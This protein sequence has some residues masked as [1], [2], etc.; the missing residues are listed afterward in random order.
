[1]KP[2]LTRFLQGAL[3]LVGLAALAFL[4]WE[5]HVEG[6]NSHATLSEIYFRDPFLA[7]V[8][9]GST[10]FFVAL[11]RAFGLLG[12]LRQNGTVSQGTVDALRV[13]ARC[14]IALIAFV[15]LGVVFIVLFGDREDRPAGVFMGLLFTVVSGVL[16]GV[17]AMFARNVRRTLAGGDVGCGVL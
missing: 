4:L 9:L 8:Y 7:Y 10:P 1:M 11:Y 17:V 13:M 12:Q 3:V 15:A 16:T 6:R 2:F 5:P 14:G